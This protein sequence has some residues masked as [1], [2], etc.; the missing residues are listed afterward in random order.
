MSGRNVQA[1]YNYLRASS[2]LH[3]SR[4]E[5][6][7]EMVLKNATSFFPS[8]QAPSLVIFISHR[9]QTRVNP[10]P[11]GSQLRAIQYV[12]QH[13]PKIASLSHASSEERLQCLPSL[14]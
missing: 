8:G 12:L 14:R 11:V 1:R 10:D 9:W 13:I 7:D 3:L 4:L 5:P 2:V 6:Y